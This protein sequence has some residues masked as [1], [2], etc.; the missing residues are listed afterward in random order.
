MLSVAVALSLS[1]LLGG[2]DHGVGHAVGRGTDR[3]SGAGRPAAAA[4]AD[5]KPAQGARPVAM[6]DS[7]LSATGAR[8]TFAPRLH[9]ALRANQP[10]RAS[11]VVPVAGAGDLALSLRRFRAVAPDARVEIG[12]GK[13]APSALLDATLRGVVHFEG[14]VDGY[15]N[16]SCYLAFGATGAAGWIDLGDGHG[17]FT[18][19]GAG[20]SP[21]RTGLIAGEAAFV[22]TN[23]TSAPE[24]P[25]CGGALG[26]D[27]GG[28]GGTAGIGDI[29]PGVRKVV[30]LAV[31]SDYEFYAIFGDAAAA[32][33]YVAALN[34]A[35]SAIYR[36]DCDATIVTKY[37]RLQNDPADLFNEP[38]PLGPFR[39]HWAPLA[40][41]SRDLFTLYTGRR[42]LP[43]GG[44]AWLNAACGDYGFSVNG[45]LIG[46]FT[47]AVETNP[48]NWD[49]NVVAHE[50]GHNLGTRHTHDYAL[51]ACASGAVQRG[52]IMSYCHVV[53][54]A[55]ANIDLRFHRG[56][57]EPIETFMAQAACLASD[58]DDDGVMDGDEIT[59]NPALDTN[60]DG[61]LDACQDCNGNGMP[62]P[63]EIA[64]ELVG[65]S[66]GDGL[67][68]PCE[69]DCDGDGVADS[70]EISLDPALDS[71]GDMRLDACQPDCNGNG[72]ADAVEINA[73]MT[74][75]RSRDG[76][77]DACED[78]DGDGVPDFAELKGSRS[79]WVAS[80]ADSLLRELDPRSGVVRRTVACGATPP[81]DL[82]IGVDGRLHAAVGNRVW[83]L[84]RVNDTAATQWSV[85]LATTVRGLAVAPDGRLAAL[86]SNGRIDLL[87]ADGTIASTFV[88][89]GLATNARDI[90]FRTLPDG[91]RDAL[92]SHDAGV[93]ARY[94]WPGGAGRVLATAPTGERALRGMHALSD[95]SFLVISS[96]ARGIFRYGASGA[97]VG[98]WSVESGSLLIAPHSLCDAGDGRTILA[99][100]GSSSSTVNGYNAASGYLERTFRVYPTDAPGATAI[101]V[102]PPSTSDANGNLVPDE[103]EPVAGDLNG[104]GAV[105]GAD[106]AALLAAWG[107]CGGCAADLDGN[108]S[109]GASDLAIL[110]AAWR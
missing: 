28:E 67:P 96:E 98:A 2:L 94:P 10:E 4:S 32:T 50:F 6:P 68:D 110:L 30:E 66:D 44:V 54:G 73:D 55:S 108:G 79:R 95:G 81:N 99:T 13:R 64:L 39:D 33:E 11:L 65:D 100:A 72:V 26:H 7:W 104:D 106:L 102:A 1:S 52:T 24:V 12:S 45:Y 29:P 53:Q 78:C 61:I 5:A 31:D 75:D 109:V 47:D 105:N 15:P 76:R 20:S 51:D 49:I 63:V 77:I 35:V 21:D 36:R 70:L 60:G 85:A 93:I 87:A 34:G 19:Q 27:H 101:V 103:C 62:D 37:L 58:C 43:Y 57:V 9:E 83:A 41:P 8:I 82:A 92:V 90:V 74:L 25:A 3:A 84:D 16:S 71:D 97:R 40:E 22:R 48:G 88:A 91:T 46:A 107:E 56:T 59:A 38:D 17:H 80:S 14:A 42:N 23:G 18:L 89:A 69:R 86:L